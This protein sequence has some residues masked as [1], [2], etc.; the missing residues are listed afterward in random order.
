MAISF[1]AL[2]VLSL[3]GIIPDWAIQLDATPREGPHLVPDGA[4]GQCILIPLGNS[5]LGGWSSTGVPLPG[6]PLSRGAGVVWKPAA[7]TG[8]RGETLIA[9]GDNDGFVH[10]VDLHGNSA[11][12]WPVNTGSS[13]ITGVSAVDLNCD[14]T[15]DI[16][17]GTSNGLVW[18]LDTRGEAVSG[19]P[20]NLN[21]Q[22]MWQPTQVSL[23]GGRGRGLVCALNNAVITVLDHRGSP[24]PGWPVNLQSPVGSNPI[25]ADVNGDGLADIIF[26]CQNRR[27]NLFSSQGRMHENWPVYLDARPV[28]GAPAVGRVNPSM[29]TPQIAVATIDSLVY[30]VNGDGSLAGAWRWPNK[31]E[32]PPFQPLIINTSR[33]PGVLAATES[34]QVYGWEVSGRAIRGFP[35]QHAGGVSFTPVA[36]DLNGDGM[37]QLVLLGRGGHLGVYSL[38]APHLTLGF[39]NLPLGDGANSGMFGCENLPVATVGELSP[40][41]TGD[42]EIPFTVSGSGYTG[43]SLYYSI[44]AGYTWTETRS[45]TRLPDRVVWHTGEDLAHRTERQV[46]V[47]ITPYYPG[48]PGECGVSR[49]I[50]VD[51][52]TPPS[53]FLN[54][55]EDLGDG[56]YR[57]TY[58]VDDPEGDVIQIQAQ[59]STDQ[60][61]SWQMMHLSGTTLEIEPWFYGEPFQWNA[62]RDL[63]PVSHDSL[64]IRVRAADSKPGPWHVIENLAVTTERLSSAQIV[65]PAEKVSGRV[66]LGVRL[67]D[68]ESSPMDVD[69]EYSTDGGVTWHR[70]TV[71]EAEGA[72]VFQHRFEIAWLSE[73]DL[74]GYS[75][76]RVRFRALPA[77]STPGVAVPSAPFHLDNNHPPEVAIVS[78]SGYGLYRGLVPVSFRITDREGDPIRLELQYRL[79][80]RTGW[81]TAA[82]VVNS[83]PFGPE[84]YN[85]ALYWNS[86]VDLPGS[87]VSDV[88][89][90]LAAINGDTTLSR[91][92]GPIALANTGLPEVV[93]ITMDPIED[94]SSTALISYEIVDPGGRIIDLE[95]H[96]SIDGG[97]TWKPSTVSESLAGIGSNSYSGVFQWHW[98]TDTLNSHGTVRL[99]VTPRFEGTNAGRPRFMEQVFR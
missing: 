20:V 99:R 46:S 94:G 22:L 31:T 65:A 91:E 75:G 8:H 60:G 24:L 47:K 90:R 12:G 66:R 41:Y 83:G 58:A 81:L 56:R 42:V 17:F 63:G 2:L 26:A 61:E 23:G 27:L 32:S 34:G 55:P 10:L 74:P 72:G 84:A 88:L 40:R 98:R 3:H 14:G 64:H 49:I 15:H 69:Y 82:G 73:A 9:Y 35:F 59:F 67:P 71:V 39:W 53:L 36:G 79:I 43:I 92:A 62:A 70:A 28:R 52:N 19:W 51:N 13:I 25:T 89:I 86:S 21:S 18:L 77:D 37:G 76:D 29:N 6:F 50:H 97:K 87:E 57:F 78:P 54:Y 33:G 38:S 5:G 11:P 7:L 4:G 93:R 85:S 68:P 80:S 95:V 30:L 16:A 48:G 44:N 1:F 96:H 45:F